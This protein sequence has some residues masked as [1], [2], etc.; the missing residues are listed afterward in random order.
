M[1][2]RDSCTFKPKVKKPVIQAKR[3][4]KLIP[5]GYERSVNR[6]RQANDEREVL[7]KEEERFYSTEDYEANRARF[8]SVKPFDFALEARKERP[9]PVL[10]MEV[11]LGV[12]KSG[13]IGIYEGDEPAVLAHNFATTYQ[14]DDEMCMRLEQLIVD[15]LQQAGH[16]SPQ[17][18]DWSVSYTHLTLPTKRIV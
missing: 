17:R 9:T 13:R 7:K 8:Q 18:D 5:R 6:V 12:G 3:Q 15:Q 10:V 11:N 14:L 2:I 4:P 1:C 16:S